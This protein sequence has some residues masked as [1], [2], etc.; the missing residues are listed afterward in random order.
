MFKRRTPERQP[1]GPPLDATDPKQSSRYKE[2]ASQA[3]FIESSRRRATS[4]FQQADQTPENEVASRKNANGSDV[5]VFSG[6]GFT[7]MPKRQF[8]RDAADAELAKANFAAEEARK[9]YGDLLEVGYGADADPKS[10]RQWAYAKPKHTAVMIEQARMEKQSGQ[11]APSSPPLRARAQTTRPNAVQDIVNRVGATATSGLASIPESFGRLLDTLTPTGAETVASQPSYARLTPEQRALI[12]SHQGSE[13]EKAQIA[14]NMLESNKALAAMDINERNKQFSIG[15][16]FRPLTRAGQR[17]AETVFPTDPSV[18]GSANPLKPG[19]YRRTLPEAVGSTIPFM[20]SHKVGTG[21]GLSGRTVAGAGGVGLEV[22][23]EYEQAEKA[24]ATPEQLKKIVQAATVAGATEAFGAESLLGKIGLKG[25]S[26]PGHLA[27]EILGEA[28]QEASQSLIEDLGAKYYARTQPNLTAEQIAQNALE[29]AVPAAFLGAGG[30]VAG[31]PGHRAEQ[32]ASQQEAAKVAAEPGAPMNLVSTVPEGTQTDVRRIAPKPVDLVSQ[33]AQQSNQQGGQQA[34]QQ[35]AAAQPAQPIQAVEPTTGEASLLFPQATAPTATEDLSGLQGPERVAKMLENVR[36]MREGKTNATIE[37]QINKD[38]GDASGLLDAAETSWDTD[39][40]SA[41]LYVDHGVKKLKASLQNLQNSPGYQAELAAAAQGQALPATPYTS[42]AQSINQRLA[43]A[44]ALIRRDAENERALKESQA[45]AEAAQKEAEKLQR[46]NEKEQ[47]KAARIQTREELQRQREIA[48]EERKAQLAAER[49]AAAEVRR[50]KQEAAKT[51]R[52]AELEKM[53]ANAQNERQAKVAEAELQRMASHDAALKAADDAGQRSQ[54]FHAEGKTAEAVNELVVQ[55]NQIRDAVKFLPRTPEAQ[56]TK[57]DL[58]RYFGQVGNRIGDLRREARGVRGPVTDAIPPLMRPDAA[59]NPDGGVPPVQSFYTPGAGFERLAAG[60]KEASDDQRPLLTAIRQMGGISDDGDTSGELRRLGVKESGTTGIVNNRT[61]LSPDEMRAQL[62]EDGYLPPDSTVDD[63]YQA[64]EGEMRAGARKEESISDFYDRFAEEDGGA[65]G[66]GDGETRPS[67]DDIAAEVEAEQEQPSE[68]ELDQA[69]YRRALDRSIQNRG[70]RVAPGEPGKG[71]SLSGFNTMLSRHAEKIDRLREMN[72]NSPEAKQIIEEIR[73]DNE[74]MAIEYNRRNL[75]PHL[76]ELLTMIMSDQFTALAEED[77]D[78]RE[79]IIEEARA[80]PEIRRTAIEREDAAIDEIFDDEDMRELLDRAVSGDENAIK[81]FTELGV[82][83]YGIQQETAAD[84]IESRVIARREAKALRGYGLA[85]SNAPRIAEQGKGPEQKTAGQL[86]DRERQLLNLKPDDIF[87]DRFDDYMAKIEDIHARAV[88]GELDIDPQTI[89]DPARWVGLS[90]EEVEQRRAAGER[91]PIL[92]RIHAARSAR[93]E[94]NRLP[95]RENIETINKYMHADLLSLAAPSKKNRMS[96]LDEVINAARITVEKK[97]SGMSA[98]KL[99][100]VND[101]LQ[102]A[103]SARAEYLAANSE[104]ARTVSHPDPAIDGKRILATTADGRVIVENADNQAGISVVKDRGAEALTD[105]APHEFSSTQ[106]NLSGSIAEKIAEFAKRIPDADLADDGRE[107]QPHI[108]VKYGLHGDNADEVRAA[109]SGEKPI[110]VTFGKVSLFQTNDDYDVVK[111]DVDSPDLH[112]LNKKIAELPHTDTF[113]DYKP[114]ATIAYVKKGKGGKYAGNRFLN[115]QVARLSSLVF[116][117]KNRQQV[118]IQLD[119]KTANASTQ[120]AIDTGGTIPAE[121]TNETDRPVGTNQGDLFGERGPEGVPA[122]DTVRQ[123]GRGSQSSSRSGGAETVRPA[124]RRGRPGISEGIRD[125]GIENALF[126]RQLEEQ[127]ESDAV[128]V[129]TAPQISVD[130]ADPSRTES[131]PPSAA[132]RPSDYHI[133]DLESVTPSGKLTKLRANLDAIRL[134]RDL[135]ADGRTPTTEEQRQLA[136][137][138]GWGQFPDLFN[139]INEAGKKL[140]VERAELKELLSPEEYERAKRSTLN[141]HYTSPKV[142]TKMWEMMR[143]MGFK[144]GR[145]QEPSMGVGHFFG[146]MP[147]DMR[148]QSQLSGVELEPTTGAIARMLYPSANIEIKGFEDVK[149]ADNFY[150]LVIGNVPFGAFRVHDPEYNRFRANIHDYFILK[151]LDKV[152]PGGVVAVITSTGTMDKPETSIRKEIAKRGRLVAA[153]RFPEGAFQKNAGTAVVTDLLIFEKRSPLSQFNETPADF[154]ETSTMPDPDGGEPI[155]INQYFVSHPEAILGTLDRKSRMYGK[156]D[157]HVTATPDFEERLKNAIE[158]LIPENVWEAWQPSKSTMADRQRIKENTDANLREGAFTVKDGKVYRRTAQALTE[159]E[160]DKKDIDRMSRMIAVRDTL[161]DLVA[162]QLEG[163][164]TVGARQALTRAYDRFVEKYG[165]VRKSTNA[166]LLAR[167]PSSYLIL[168]LE[169]SYDPKTQRAKKADIFTKDVIAR[170]RRAETA[171]GPAEAMAASLFESGRLDLDRVAGLLGV[172]P[173]EAARQMVSAGL[174]YEDPRGAWETAETYLSGNVRKKLVEAREAAK[175]DKKYRPN[176]EALEKVQPEDV[177]MEHISVKLGASWIPAEDITHFASH[178]LNASPEGF[179]IRHVP[180]SGVWLAAFTKKIGAIATS[181]QATEVYGTK[182]ADFIDVLESALNDQPI[183]VYDQVTKDT[184]VLNQQATEEANTKV[185]EVK[186]AFND[187]IWSDSDRAQRLHRY[188]N[189]NFNNLRSIQYTGEHYKGKDGRYVL[190]G[191]NPQMDLRP[192]QIKDVWQAV[193]NGKLL[194]ASEVG[195]G[196]TYILGSIAMEWR[197]LGLA[198]KPAIVVPKS[199]MT[200]TVEEIQRLYPGAKILSLEKSFDKENRKKTTAQMATGDYDIVVMSHEQMDK[201]PMRPEVIQEFIGAELEEINERIK[202]AEEEAKDSGTDKREGNRIVKQLEKVKQRIETKLKEA[203]DASNKDDATF[204]E[205]TGIDALLVDE[206][207]AFKALPVYSRRTGIKGV[208]TSRSDRATNMYMRSRWLFRQNGG[209]GLVFATGTPVTNTLTEVYNMQRYLQHAELVERGI[210]NFDAWADA[211][212]NV[213]TNFEYT[214]SGEFK[215][216][217]RMAEF[218][219]LPELQQMVRQIMAT[220]FVDDMPWVSRPTKHEHV[221]TSPMTESQVA[222]LQEIRDRIETLKKM[223]PKQRKESGDNFLVVSTDARKSAMTTKL[224]TPSWGDEDGKIKALADKVLELHKARP[225]VTQMIF[226][227]MGVSETRWGYS[228]Y[229]EIEN[230]LIAGGIPKEKIA[231][232]ARITDT[233]RQQVAQKL[234]DGEYLIGIGSSGKMGTG[235]NAQR[236]LAALHHLDAP[237]VPAFLEQRN[238]RAHRQGNL[239]DPSKPENQQNIDVYYYTTEG[240]FDVVMWQALD[241]KSRFIKAFM[242]GDLSVRE[243]RMD[244]TGDEDTGEVSPEMILAA[245]SGNP[246]ELD[247]VKLTQDI[248]RL[249]RQQKNWRG[250]QSRFKTSISENE[251]RVPRMRSAIEAFEKDAADYEAAREGKF[252]A[253]IDGKEYD[254]REAAGNQLA[255]AFYGA[256][257]Y[258]DVKLGEYR[259]FE[260]RANKGND[261]VYLV[262]NGPHHSFNLQL[263]APQGAFQSADFQLRNIAAK[264][265]DQKEQIKQRER[266]IETAKA[267][268]GKPF[269]RADELAEKK[270]QLAEIQKK[271]EALLEAKKAPA[272]ETD[273]TEEGGI[274]GAVKDFLK[275]EGG[276]ASLGLGI[277]QIASRL[278]NQPKTTPLRAILEDHKPLIVDPFKIQD[279]TL[280]AIYKAGTEGTL[281]GARALY[282]ADKLKAKKISDKVANFQ[283]NFI[284][285]ML[286]KTNKLIEASEAMAQAARGGREYE[287]AKKKI[288]RLNLQIANAISRMGE[289]THPAAYAAKAY[290]TNLLSAPH[291]HLFN[292]LEQIF[293]FPLHEAQRAI[294]FMVPTKTF[295]KWGIP[296]EKGI[297]DFRDLV[298]AIETELRGLATGLARSPRDIA[299]M[300]YY[301]VTRQMQRMDAAENDHAGGTDKFELGHRAKMIPGLDQVINFIGRTHGAADIAFGNMV[302]ASLIGAQANAQA[303]KIGKKMGFTEKGIRDLARDLANEPSAA[304]VT[305]ASDATERFKLDYPTLAYDALQALRNLPVEKVGG[306]HLGEAYKAALDFVVPF[307]KIPLAAVDTYLFRYSPVGLA[308]TAGRL[309]TANSRKGTDKPATGRYTGEMA[310]QRHAEDTAELFRQGAIGT[311]SWALMGAL[312]SFG[313]IKFQGGR[314]DDDDRRNVSNVKEILGQDYK[315]EMVAGDRAYNLHRMGPLGEATAIGSR[316]YQAGQPRRNPLTG[317]P[318]DAFKRAGRVAKAAWEGGVLNNPL[319]SAAKDI[320]GDDSHSSMI[321]SYIGGKTRGLVP[322]LLRDIAKIQNPTKVVPDDSSLGARLKAGVQSGMP[323]DAGFGSR[324]EM[325]PRLDALG[326]PVEEPNPFQ[327][328]RPVKHDPQ[329]E[330]MLRLGVGIGKPQRKQGVSSEKYNQKI[331][332]R[333]Q[334]TREALDRIA[335]DPLQASRPDAAKARIYATELDK[336]GMQRGQKISAESQ[337][338]ENQIEDLRIQAYQELRATPQWKQMD[339]EERDAARKRIDDQ[340][341]V[342]RATAGHSSKTRNGREYYVKEKAASAPGYSPEDLARM[343]LGNVP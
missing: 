153:L 303:R 322:G 87:D 288:E 5:P 141:A 34:G 263:S 273:V 169:K 78:L 256:P 99:A 90:P 257:D 157:A 107:D 13:A 167:D 265:A 115:G 91:A 57:A 259:G 155:P 232:F 2:A 150:D 18:E 1:Y 166:K 68:E 17:E 39:R 8:L 326:N 133:T 127:T 202:E 134:L 193:V 109:L 129:S 61:G 189:D 249:E 64:I 63:L 33:K 302:N 219:N 240:S 292:V 271:I 97:P 199:R 126:D 47:A 204:F 50:Q 297:T 46:K 235:I 294:D 48:V 93:V 274:V 21:M 58:N 307:S 206:A 247:R 330:E 258:R 200:P 333:A 242:K 106:V 59:V 279:Q 6:Q 261:L 301:G 144:G 262:K 123:T 214:A 208:P 173:E 296:Y 158:K 45:A 203:L 23:N 339:S 148:A 168:A 142:I 270:V 7:P 181:A 105:N 236:R 215:P 51:A 184:R 225:D 92:N 324:K 111:V 278:F 32:R 254:N 100:E 245:T 198:R 94:E 314:E 52:R 337:E 41:E 243:M 300:L 304:I 268:I 250:Q 210:D 323:F 112:R 164:N 16:K 124:R 140:D 163:S 11:P 253:T 241:R 180:A 218:V 217:S 35:A 119:G 338:V 267:E 229:N 55:Q 280:D 306:R 49:S 147:L 331:V 121:A 275:E 336:Q 231:N 54:K 137:F 132:A 40:P 160:M 312:A 38:F 282:W 205:E 125:V 237:W 321:G 14:A 42:A 334:M 342:Y 77:G 233:Q 335:A 310:A 96:R 113:P 174:A 98:A 20:I 28:G 272:A 188:Y 201:M 110:K 186:D 340:L 190:P 252:S 295:Q 290:K 309:V 102:R 162:A 136:Q 216:V 343:A 26:I 139:D 19:F 318:E 170:N 71:K 36:R 66:R 266:D 264:A 145:V 43:R 187:W 161:N 269:K 159:V 69:A 299:D 276:S 255:A 207:H 277:P 156:G 332:D 291:I 176:V 120:E 209:R 192:N 224:V 104:E 103:L 74:K 76:D 234:N 31:I 287:A 313:Y 246:Y 244:D 320:A 341:K 305:L 27:K 197:R 238:G 116:S 130:K 53:R 138:I 117:D 177:P 248:E 10:K 151:S 89:Q 329:L 286:D 289:Y 171:N 131:Q 24:G 283:A 319:G 37:Q 212:S 29:N 191:M 196:K 108:T 311:I 316:M 60:Q 182:R 152:R 293:K 185:Q 83:Y 195:A 175:V 9:N 62:A 221:I 154:I 285:S 165:P 222:Y 213:A 3:A 260:I 25:K 298:P 80:L 56:N 30:G 135:Q 114:H 79:Q 67:F 128:P 226:S 12:A 284:E 178:L 84:L 281:P 172:E 223:S 95:A 228:V 86:T 118:E 227:D 194:D 211:F 15:E 317:E 22:A 122:T 88:R 183:R 82:G 220:N 315:Q 85:Q 325:A 81:D 327:F 70:E 251:A 230:R 101:L 4:L 328:S 308:R 65:E 146:L 44:D 239:N 73:A 179:N 143:Q 75:T 72:L 149:M